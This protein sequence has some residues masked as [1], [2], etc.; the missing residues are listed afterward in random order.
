MGTHQHLWAKQN[1]LEKPYPLLAHLLDS[2]TVAGALWDLW[3][4]RGLR[5]L[6]IDKLGNQAREIIQFVIGSHDIGKATPLF[7]FQPKQKSDLWEGIRDTITNVG[8]YPEPKRGSL[9]MRT[10]FW[11]ADRHEQWS[12]FAHKN[13]YL[14]PRD[15][16][17]TNWIELAVG[18]HHGMF[19]PVSGGGRP[20]KAAQELNESVFSQAQQDLLEILA[21]TCGIRRIDLPHTLSSE[22]TLVLSGLTILADRI[23]SGDPFVEAGMSLL[24]TG[25]LSLDEP[26]KWLG[27]RKVEAE[28]RVANTVGIYQGWDNLEEAQKAILSEHTPRS[29]QVKAMDSHDGLLNLMAETGNGKTE[30]AILRHACEP[31]ERLIFLLPTQAT[32][33]AIMRRIQKIYSGTSNVASLAHSLATVEDFY[34]TPLSVYD[35]QSKKLRVSV[36]TSS[37]TSGLYPSSFVR[38]GSARLLAPICVGTIDQALATSLPGKWIHLR[39]LALAN[40]HIVI[41]EV[42]TLD[43]Y[44]TALLENLLPCLSRLGT[45]I[46]FLTATMPSWQ[47]DRLLKAYG[48]ESLEAPSTEFPAAENVTRSNFRRH[49]LESQPHNIDF[50]LEVADYTDLVDSHVK[51]HREMRQLAPKARIG[52]ICN[53]V[54]RAQ[55][56]AEL[57]QHEGYQVILLHSRMTAEHRRRSAQMLEM[58]LGPDGDG[59]EITVIGTQ[60]I[61]ASLDIDLDVLRTE[62][63]PAPSLLQRAG[64]VWRRHDPNRSNRISA[65]NKPISVVSITDPSEYDVLPYLLAETT[66]TDNWLRQHQLVQLPRMAQ[67]FIDAAT[68]DFETAASEMDLEALARMGIKTM[69]AHSAKARFADLMGADARAS[70]FELLTQRDEATEAST[71]LIDEGTQRRLILGGSKDIIPGAWEGGCESLLRLH[72]N[73]R[74]KLRQA[75]R[76]SVAIRVTTEMQEKMLVAHGLKRLTESRTVLSQFYYLP[77]AEDFYDQELGFLWP[78][79][80]I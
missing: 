22:L 60:A 69:K 49:I 63:S 20:G 8:G 28:K 18:G 67:E 7:Q 42:H 48:G 23:A 38:S 40:A 27:T 54:K 9:L 3:L 24:E 35:D 73:D 29:L 55:K 41:D 33:N 13:G 1:G 6:F 75:L 14:E 71:R 62:T 65:Q 34:Q 25:K 59:E 68:V 30:A 74:D 51:W 46:T 19:V 80:E 45:R 79:E 37:L 72:S 64:R 2:A 70:D 77:D 10:G 16:A 61:E 5:E 58:L 39:L 76:A 53:T 78:D 43:Q 36:E 66:R 31:H 57:I 21:D 15:H 47:R 12:S 11:G 17:E 26:R 44:Q 4:R 56:V 52:I 50:S 32:S